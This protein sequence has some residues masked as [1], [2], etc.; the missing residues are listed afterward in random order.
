MKWL[1]FVLQIIGLFIFN[2]IGGWLAA[3]LHLPLSGSLVGMMLL[4]VLLVTGVVK[5]KW[6]EDGALALLAFLP[7]FFVPTTVG[8][9]AEPALFSMQGLLLVGV[10][11][12]STCAVMVV[13][14]YVGQLLA[15][16]KEKGESARAEQSDHHL[17]R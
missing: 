4:F 5:S 15:T 17:G 2:H 13:T 14:G 3:V 6:L 11:I 9:V 16:K 8:V 1:R 7:L 12:V 10:T